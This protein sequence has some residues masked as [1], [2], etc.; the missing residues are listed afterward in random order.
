MKSDR[1]NVGPQKQ[2]DAGR[3]ESRRAI[4][5]IGGGTR[6]VRSSDRKGRHYSD[7]FQSF[8]T[9]ISGIIIV[10]QSIART[11]SSTRSFHSI[12]LIASVHS[13]RTRG[14]WPHCIVVGMPI[15]ARRFFV[16]RRCWRA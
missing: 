2:L 3:K 11:Y 13:I 4:R 1:L 8:V 5:N 6:K 7:R 15:I 12:A 9:Y 16:L 14:R 10:Q